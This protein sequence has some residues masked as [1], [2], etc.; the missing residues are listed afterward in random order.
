[1][2]KI[3]R[4]RNAQTQSFEDFFNLIIDKG[5][6]EYCDSYQECMEIMGQE[7]IEYISGNGCNAFDT[8]VDRIKKAFLL[9]KC[10]PIGT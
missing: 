9:E 3:K 4:F 2:D 10:V 1:M 6:C 8:S 7:N 5:V